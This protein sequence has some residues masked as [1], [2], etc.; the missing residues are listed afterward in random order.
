VAWVLTEGGKEHQGAMSLMEHLEEDCCND[1]FYDEK[2]FVVQGMGIGAFYPLRG[3]ILFSK[4]WIV[5]KDD[6][7]IAIFT[8]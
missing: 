4:D 5:R 2:F 1:P 3:R 6:P 7:V 8:E